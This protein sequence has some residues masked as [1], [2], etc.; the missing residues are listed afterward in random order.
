MTPR[1]E[2]IALPVETTIAAA[3]NT[4]L[5]AKHS[6]LP[7]FR[8]SIDNVVGVLHVRDLFLAWE[9]HDD[10]R[11]ISP[12]MRAVTYVP[13]PLTA[14]ELLGMMRLKTR[15]A[16]VVDEYGG[17]AGLVTLEDILEEI[18][19]E[20]REEHDQ[21]DEDPIREETAGVYII[22]AVTHVKEVE[23]LFDIEFED[24]DFDT[25]SGLVVS[26][27]GRV[28][29]KHEKLSTHGLCIEVL[30]ADPRRVISV[31]INAESDTNPESVND[32]Q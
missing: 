32:E 3:R 8:G 19:G 20:I 13:E 5:E 30:K 4:F 7:I 18:V 26:L 15:M 25:V 17:V 1:T 21:G 24:R 11:S 23:A 6:R 12:Y 14:A 28:P 16:I 22:A 27:A 31:R 2:I 9:D 29:A 10:S